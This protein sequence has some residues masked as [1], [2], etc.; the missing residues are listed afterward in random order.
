M[1][2][3]V[4]SSVGAQEMD[5]GGHQVPDL[6]DIEFHWENHQLDVDAVFGPRSDTLFSPIALDDLDMGG[7]RPPF[8]ARQNGSWRELTFNKIGL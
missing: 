3:K 1:R 2:D 5:T 4:L 8:P 7:S 6:D